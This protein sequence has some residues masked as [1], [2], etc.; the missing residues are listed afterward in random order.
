MSADNFIQKKLIRTFG[1]SMLPLLHN[2]DI[3][4][5]SKTAFNKLQVN[6]VVI[7]KNK[8]SFF[9]HR[10]IYKSDLF[11]ITKGDNNQK[12]DGKIYKNKVVGKVY[13]VKRDGMLINI[14]D[15][16]LI[17]STIYF[18]EIQKL[19]RLF[20]CE[21]IDYVFLKGLPF[22]INYEGRHPKRIYADCDILVNKKDKHKIDNIM[23][24]LG[25]NKESLSKFKVFQYFL[26]PEIKEIKYIK[27]SNGLRVVFDVHFE[28][29]IFTHKTTLPITSLQKIASDFTN[30]IIVNKNFVNIDSVKYPVLEIHDLI[31]YLFLHLFNHQWSNIQQLNFINT[32]ISKEKRI[33]DWNLLI[34]QADELRL[35]N[36]IIPGIYL[37]AK[38][39]NF[40]QPLKIIKKK[41]NKK[42]SYSH[43]IYKF[44]C[45]EHDLFD[46]HNTTEFTRIKRAALI[47]LLYDANII[48]RLVCIFH[49]KLMLHLA[50]YLAT[51]S[52][53]K[54]TA[55]GKTLFQPRN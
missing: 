28:T 29:T 53:N 9:V 13:K 40:N 12:S 52:V 30:R 42:L 44:F 26:E 46:S 7:V 38:F 25:F 43:A 50:V 31:L 47:L 33:I 8:E 21:K 24:K 48:K 19:M 45:K 22:H 15:L 23:S 37:L 20:S 34:K 49:P 5:F 3:V 18:N 54:L 17:Q 4:Y 35:L 11:I 6:D 1:D 16:Y 27:N 14:A 36:Y 32:V 55:I 39:Y 51:I 10:I 2:N 41:Y